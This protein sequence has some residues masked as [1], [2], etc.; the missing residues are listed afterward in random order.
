M[1]KDTLHRLR[2]N[3][4]ARTTAPIRSGDTPDLQRFIM[5]GLVVTYN[6]KTGDNFVHAFKVVF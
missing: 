2:M 6:W 4:R 3:R 1:D 5:G